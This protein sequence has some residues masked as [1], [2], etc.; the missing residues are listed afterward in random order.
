MIPFLLAGALIVGV[1]VATAFWK[2]IKSFIQA[3]IERIKPT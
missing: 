2:E 1:F 3:S